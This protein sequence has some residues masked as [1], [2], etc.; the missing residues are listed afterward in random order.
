MIA[1]SV[2]ENSKLEENFAALNLASTRLGRASEKPRS[3]LTS[4]EGAIVVVG[5]VRLR[6]LV[7][8]RP[9]ILN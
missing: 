6:N 8:H 2:G 3:I 5:K 4:E 7:R 9:W 1:T